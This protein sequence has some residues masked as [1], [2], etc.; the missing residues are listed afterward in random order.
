MKKRILACVLIL[1]LIL[2]PTLSGCSKNDEG[3][4][5]TVRLC[6]VTHSIFYAPQYVAIAKGFF[7]EENIT[8]ELS[9]GGGAD[10]VMSAVISNSVDIG[11]AGPEA[12]V[13]VYNSG[14]EDYPEVFAQL[15]ACDG[16]FLV[17]REPDPDFKWSDLAGTHILPGRTGG[18]PYMAFRYAM[19]ENGINPDTD[20]NLDNTIQFDMMTG[21]FLGGTGDYVTMFE[22]VASSVQLE[23]KGYIVASVGAAAGEMPYT[24]YFAKKSYIK[25]NSDLIQRFTNAV[26]KGQKWVKEHTSEEIAECVKDFFADTDVTLLASAVK[27][28]KDIGAF[29]TT[30]VMTEEAFNRLQEVIQRAGELDSPAPF[31]KLIN[32]TFANKAIG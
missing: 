14:S 3:G 26:A 16:S 5:T 1:I 22:P 20:A 23:G 9:N 24:A 17:G 2:V 4:I 12:S 6:E 32:N 7:E 19:E 28:Y 27:S 29:A 11:L 25:E 8:I 18:M 13:Y 10:K 30:P 31:D 21:A 15:T